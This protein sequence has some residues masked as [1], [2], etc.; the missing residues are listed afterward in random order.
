MRL[1]NKRNTLRSLSLSKL[2]TIIMP[3]LLLFNVS[4]ETRCISVS[5]L[6]LVFSISYNSSEEG[7]LRCIHNSTIASESKPIQCRLVIDSIDYGTHSIDQFRYELDNQNMLYYVEWSEGPYTLSEVQE[8]LTDFINTSSAS[9]AEI[10]TA[11]TRINEL[12]TKARLYDTDFRDLSFAISTSN[13]R[14]FIRTI[15]SYNETKPFV[16]RYEIS[17]Q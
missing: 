12:D 14:I 7:D 8:L 10:N 11:I 1:T 6:N 2:I 17:K 9:T 13:A 5:E 16:L 15:F 4:C 3:L